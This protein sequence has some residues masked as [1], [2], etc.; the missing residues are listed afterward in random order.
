[1]S[2]MDEWTGS[3]IK[4]KEVKKEG[5]G[6]MHLIDLPAFLICLR[7][8]WSSWPLVNCQLTPSVPCLG[9]LGLSCSMERPEKLC[10]TS[11]Y[12]WHVL[13]SVLIRPFDWTVWRFYQIVWLNIYNKSVRLFSK[14]TAGTK[15]SGSSA[16]IW[17]I[18]LSWANP[19]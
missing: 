2:R 16:V 3:Q 17:L 18:I 14:H 9:S 13:L 5:E 7:V 11:L 4:P 10:S 1:M 19:P 15:N 8:K 6:G 12:I